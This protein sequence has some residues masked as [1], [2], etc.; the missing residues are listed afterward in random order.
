MLALDPG[1]E[2]SLC[3]R[4]VQCLHGFWAKYVPALGRAA[5]TRS[6]GR[7]QDARASLFLTPSILIL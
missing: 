7:I 3:S 5:I 1:T 2:E 6:P 4:A